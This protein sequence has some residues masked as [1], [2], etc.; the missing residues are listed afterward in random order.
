MEIFVIWMQNCHHEEVAAL[1][2][3]VTLEIIQDYSDAGVRSYAMSALQCMTQYKTV[4]AKITPQLLDLFYTNNNLQNTYQYICELFDL[5]IDKP[6]FVWYIPI[7]LLIFIY[8]VA[9]ILAGYPANTSA[10]VSYFDVIATKLSDDT[11][12]SDVKVYTLQLL[13]NMADGDPRVS[14]AEI[15]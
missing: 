11:T 9:I 2:S 10:I 4:V 5:S 6:S 12:E 15:L 1:F 7:D 3:S 8:L 14:S 13:Q